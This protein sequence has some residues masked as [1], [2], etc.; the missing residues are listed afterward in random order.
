VNVF[1]ESNFV[2]EVALEQREAPSCEALL[3][4]A[5]E[6]TIRLLLPAYSLIEPHETL[7]RRH[8]DREAL[9]SG[10]SKELAQLA[11]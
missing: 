1:V 6:G 7:T 9:R 11:R 4:L 10:V 2:I 8:L 5:E 3:Q